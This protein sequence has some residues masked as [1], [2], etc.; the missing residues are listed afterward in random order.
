MNKAQILHILKEPRI[1]DEKKLQIL[2]EAP[3]KELPLVYDEYI[4][5]MWGMCCR[6]PAHMHFITKQPGMHKFKLTPKL[7]K[8]MCNQKNY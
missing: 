2:E 8:E 4:V 6:I 7:F 5:H 1:A 3:E